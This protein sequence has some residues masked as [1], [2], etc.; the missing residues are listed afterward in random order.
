MTTAAA[1][2]TGMLSWM[3]IDQITQKRF[4]LVG[5]ST[6]AIAGLASV[7]LGAGYIPVWAA[8]LTGLVASPICWFMMRL[9]KQRFKVD[10]A[11]D[12]F[13]CHG[14]GGLL[15]GLLVG[16]FG[17]TAINPVLPNDGL[18]FSGDFTQLGIQLAS[19][20]VTIIWAGLGTLV[21]IGICRLFGNLRADERDE[22]TGLDLSQHGESAYPSFNGLD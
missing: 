6:G 21:C 8:L 3:A 9:I 14:I 13:G 11:L 16:L 10:D 17:S 4:T 20:A 19:A 7:T 12:V 18:F 5:A 15:G 2:A 1:G 22:K